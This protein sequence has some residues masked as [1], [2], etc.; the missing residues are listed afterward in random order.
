M[1]CEDPV[2]VFGERREGFGRQTV[3]GH[4]TARSG[5]PVAVSVAH[6]VG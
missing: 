4:S 1:V 6:P 5:W 3:D 2:C